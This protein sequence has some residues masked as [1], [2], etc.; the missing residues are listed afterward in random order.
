VKDPSPLIEALTSD[1]RGL[2]LQ[3]EDL[4]TALEL[5]GEIAGVRRAIQAALR[6]C[7]R[8]RQSDLVDPLTW[9]RLGFKAG[10]RDVMINE[11][12]SGSS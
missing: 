3:I 2:S 9:N 1:A 8:R 5:G 7:L 6:D 10:L 4:I 11:S 12:Q